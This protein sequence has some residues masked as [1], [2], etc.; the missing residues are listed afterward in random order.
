MYHLSWNTKNQ[1]V[2]NRK[3]DSL[4]EV[5]ETIKLILASYS[6]VKESI[7]YWNDEDGADNT[8]FPYVD[9]RFLLYWNEKYKT[10]SKMRTFKTKSDLN[11]K[12]DELATNVDVVR[13]SV[14][15]F[16]EFREPIY[17]LKT[18]PKTAPEQRKAIK[19]YNSKLSEIKIRVTPEEKEQIMKAAATAEMS[20][21]EYI[22]VKLKIRKPKK[23]K[24]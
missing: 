19:K 18:E 9:E 3:C 7:N 21:Q 2:Q 15:Y 5:K 23:K 11:K 1:K 14:M 4:N 13:N 8:Y 20:M 16:N 17:P 6:T 22:L 24:K 12:I 10:N